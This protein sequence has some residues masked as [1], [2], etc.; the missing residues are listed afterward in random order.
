VVGE[1]GRNAR[2]DV[3]KIETLLG[4][5]GTLDLQK[6]DGPT[7]YAGQ[8]LLDGIRV[9]QKQ[10]GLRVDGRLNPGGPTLKV[11]SQSLQSMGRNGDTVL[12]HITPEEAQVLHNITDGGLIN[13]KTGLLEFWSGDHESENQGGIGGANDA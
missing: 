10:N 11:L 1:G 12:A 9:F 5:A 3:A 13:L 2:A 4:L 8:R 7:G 6:T